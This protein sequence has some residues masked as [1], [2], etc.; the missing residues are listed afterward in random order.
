MKKA[1]ILFGLMLVVSVLAAQAPEAF[2]LQM[3][4]R[5]NGNVLSNT[6]VGVRTSIRNANTDQ[7]LYMETQT[8]TTNVNGLV[9]LVVGNGV[10]TPG[11]PQFSTI[12]WGQQLYLKAEIDPDGGTNYSITHEKPLV[13]VPYALYAKEMQEGAF[14]GNYNDLYNRPDIPVLPIQVSAFTNDPPYITSAQVEQQIA[15]AV[16]DSIHSRLNNL[17]NQVLN[18]EEMV[19]S[20]ATETDSIVNGGFLCGLHKVV[21]FDG[22]V[23]NTVQI[24]KQCWMRENLRVRH[25]SD[26]TEISWGGGV[27]DGIPHCYRPFSNNFFYPGFT[28]ENT[29][30]HYNWF[31][32]MNGNSASNAVPSGVQGVCPTGWHVPSMG[33]WEKMVNYVKTCPEYSCNGNPATVGK[34]LAGQSGWY[35]DTNA[36]AVGYGC[37]ASGHASTTNNKTL[38]SIMPTG[39]SAL[40]VNHNVYNNYHGYDAKVWSTSKYGDYRRNLYISNTSTGV[41]TAPTTG[42]IN[43]PYNAMPVRCPSKTYASARGED[44][45]RIQPYGYHLHGRMR[46]YDRRQLLGDGEGRMLEYTAAPHRQRASHRCRRWR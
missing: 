27:K 38:M 22:N 26:G 25:F 23:Y 1:S 43:S 35:G 4:V 17:Q 20:L 28:E 2:T 5:N 21:D 39:E 24:D 34:A 40:S 41:T 44:L 18:Q 9:T 37:S 45:P 30:L 19:D 15:N 3:V 31:A 8:A 12:N 32:V 13:S 29:G 7:L 11:T 33:E 36:C 42:A 46:P 16:Y 6:T 10:H 14:S